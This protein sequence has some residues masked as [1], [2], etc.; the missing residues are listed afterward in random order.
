MSTEKDAG[1]IK[2]VLLFMA[3]AAYIG[4]IV[5][6]CIWLL[7]LAYFPHLVYVPE[8]FKMHPKVVE[9]VRDLTGKEEMIKKIEQHSNPIPHGHFHIT[10][11]YIERMIHELETDPP[12]CLKCHGTYPHS[13]NKKTRSFTNL[14]NGFMACEVCHI[15]KVSDDQDFFFAWADLKTGKLANHAR[16]EQGK[17]QAK[18]VP[19]KK[20]DGDVVRLDEYVGEKFSQEYLEFQETYT[21]DQL[22]EVKKVHEHNLSKNPIVC[23][24]CHK[25]R[26]YM[27]FEE[28]GFSETRAI[29]LSSSE[30]PN[31]IEKY[32]TFFMPQMFAPR[33]KK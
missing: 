14:H 26:G 27:A 16:G 6:F 7:Q 21:P 10:D 3:K 31:M 23:L 15:R 25:D 18:I 2:R 29:Q 20:V 24:D 19:V 12:L 30:I 17:Y 4:P 28:L 9:T 5:I 33:K 11:E 1:L 32:D 13:K 8:F 22:A